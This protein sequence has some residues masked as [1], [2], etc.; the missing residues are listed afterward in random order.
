MKKRSQTSI[1]H[2]RGWTATVAATSLGLL[3]SGGQ[4]MSATPK[5]KPDGSFITISGT[6]VHTEP[7]AFR[8]DY[9]DGVITVEMD[10]FDEY[11]EGHAMMLNDQVEVHGVIDNDSF[12]RKTIEASSVYVENLSTHFYASAA[13]EEDFATWTASTPISLG[14]AKLTGTVTTKDGRDFTLDTGS[15]Q[16][17]VDTSSMIYNPLDDKGF[18]QVDIGDRV[19]VSGDVDHALFDAHEISADWIVELR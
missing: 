19:K 6:V 12:E 5:N 13:D 8:L 9:G 17:R 4:V 1:A 7:D 11:P 10:D 15:R 2:K 3:L 18:L 16:V 14:E